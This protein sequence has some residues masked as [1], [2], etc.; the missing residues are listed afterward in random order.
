MTTPLIRLG[1]SNGRHTASK[2]PKGSI[3]NPRPTENPAADPAPLVSS[4]TGI[5]LL[6]TLAVNTRARAEEAGHRKA[7]TAQSAARAREEANGKRAVLAQLQAQVA[8]V[9][10]ELGR[11]DAEVLRTG[12]ED[13]NA[14]R[15]RAELERTATELTEL[16]S[17]SAEKAGLPHPGKPLGEASSDPSADTQAFRA[18]QEASA[19]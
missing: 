13:E 6:W 12:V 3:V 19:P 7:E 14:E 4:Q 17:A 16:V 5:E 9:Q 11:L 18:V 15:L 10:D 8:Q 1:R 2:S